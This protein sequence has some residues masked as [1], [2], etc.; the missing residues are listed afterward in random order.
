L[1][2]KGDN[3]LFHSLKKG[4]DFVKSLLD[5]SVFEDFCQGSAE[6]AGRPVEGSFIVN[7]L[8]TKRISLVYIS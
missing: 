2:Y 5:L 8:T 4:N 6:D 7:A 3:L 1:D